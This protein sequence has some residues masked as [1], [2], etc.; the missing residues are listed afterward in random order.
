MFWVISPP[1]LKSRGSLKPTDFILEH[2]DCDI[3]IKKERKEGRER[4]GK[5]K[6]RKGKRR[7]G[8]G[9]RGEGTKGRENP[10]HV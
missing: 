8:E 7:G 4:E 2:L 6:R 10:R 1:L 9:K 3:Q 5:K